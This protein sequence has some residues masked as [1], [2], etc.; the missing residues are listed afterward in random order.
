MNIRVEYY[1]AEWNIRFPDIEAVKKY[2]VDN[3]LAKIEV[4]QVIVLEA[5]TNG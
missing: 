3:Q 2:A 1:C 4:S 5:V